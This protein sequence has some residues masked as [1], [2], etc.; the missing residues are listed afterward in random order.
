MKRVVIAGLLGGLAAFVWSALSWTVLPFQTEKF[1]T[2]PDESAIAEILAQKIT[3]AGV[4]HYPGY[5]D[6][7]S[8]AAGEQAWME[9]YS[10][11][12]VVP[13]LVVLPGP[14]DLSFTKSIAGG[15]A[16]NLA[17]GLALALILAPM[18]QLS[19]G[20][21]V[22]TAVLAAVFAALATHVPYWTWNTF[23]LPY[24]LVVISDLLVCWTI[25]GLVVAWGLRPISRP[26]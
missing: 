18:T 24:T 21:R 14:G 25:A 8:G 2:M 1:Q 5:P 12:P 4:Y 13:V 6:P 11:G 17:A 15:F 10:R 19:P 26:A 23:P 20:R 22:G 16:A 3:R 7:S 9:K